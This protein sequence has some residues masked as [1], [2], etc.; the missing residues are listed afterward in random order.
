GTGPVLHR[1]RRGPDLRT[2]HAV[3]LR[4]RLRGPHGDP[5]ADHHRAA[6]AH[7]GSPPVT[8][9]LVTAPRRGSPVGP[10]RRAAP[11]AALPMVLP[12][13]D[14]AVLATAGLVIGASG[15]AA[16]A[17]ACAVLVLLVAD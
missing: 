1:T 11:A 12:M 2:G 8:A 3:R 6:T 10:L 4:R 17:Y 7:R 14:I 5:R 13:A 15:W 16:A 9:S